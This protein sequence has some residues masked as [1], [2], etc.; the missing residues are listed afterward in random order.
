MGADHCSLANVK[1]GGGTRLGL[2]CR[3]VAQQ[4]NRGKLG[5]QVAR[6]GLRAVLI[7]LRPPP[8][9]V[10]VAED[11]WGWQ[12]TCVGGWGGGVGLVRR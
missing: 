11:V 4:H 7:N 6:D 12:V 3:E 9:L 1:G 10:G 2:G 8:L 5:A